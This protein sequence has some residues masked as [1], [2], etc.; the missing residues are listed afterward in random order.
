M[1]QKEN[2]YEDKIDS[3]K[4]EL[5]A[6]YQDQIV[7]YI[8]RDYELA[9]NRQYQSLLISNIQGEAANPLYLCDTD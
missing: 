6:Q 1:K 2:E 9:L 3:I 5:E 7:S 8:Q 4:K